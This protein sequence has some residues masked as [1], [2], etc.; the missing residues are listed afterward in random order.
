[1]GNEAILVLSETQRASGS[2][3]PAWDHGVPCGLRGGWMSLSSPP[4]GM[5]FCSLYPSV[6]PICGLR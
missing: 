5:G 2:F 3:H 1:M 4:K 6:S